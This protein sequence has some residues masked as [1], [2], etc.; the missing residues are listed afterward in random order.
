MREAIGENIFISVILCTA[1]ISLLVISFV[2]LF[3]RNQNK[4]LKHRQQIHDAEM[5]HQKQLTNAIIQ[6]QE[7][8]RK[9]IGQDLHDEVGSSLSNLRLSINQINNEANH[10]RLEE[11]AVEYK[12]MIDKIITELRDISHNLSPPALTLF[13]FS[14]ALEEL[15][16]I[17][18]NSGEELTIRIINNAESLSDELPYNSALALI[19]V[20]QELTANSIKHAVAKELSIAISL[21]E[22]KLVI[23]YADDGRGFDLLDEKYK[24]GMGMQNIESR[25]AMIHARYTITTKPG[26]GF[27][28]SIIL[29]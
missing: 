15:A 9:R 26:C 20:L 22:E 19:R 28:M 11:I 17:I 6:S 29:T 21:E 27:S 4:L 23:R 16:Y 18:N 12:D 5:N 14:T 25:L 3:A 10:N 8:E 7:L 2:L 1:G 24:H 13:G